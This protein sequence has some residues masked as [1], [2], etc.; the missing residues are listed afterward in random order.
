MGLM[1]VECALGL[2]ELALLHL[3]GHSCYKA[4]AFLKAGSAVEQEAWR[5]YGPAPAMRAGVTA[6]AVAGA[7][8]LVVAAALTMDAQGPWAPWLLLALA[9]SV[10]LSE[11]RIGAGRWPVMAVAGRAALLLGAYLILKAAFGGIVEPVPVAA[12]AAT[13]LWMLALLLGLAAGYVLLGRPT[14]GPVARRL[15][16]WLFAGFYLDEW[17]TRTTLRIWPLHLPAALRVK[18][19]HVIQEEV[20][21]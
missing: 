12:G 10:V 17:F 4:H 20:A 14:H 16:V 18:R 6:A 5:R 15:W 3:V 21:S 8:G 2:Y 1:L 19:L 9:L 11:R 7:L 13:D